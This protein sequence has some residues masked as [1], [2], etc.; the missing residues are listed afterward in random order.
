MGKTLKEALLK[1]PTGQDPDV[2][3]PLVVTSDSTFLNPA[4]K[5]KTE[6][7]DWAYA[8]LGYPLVN[9]ELTDAQFDVC[10]QNA[11]QLYTK[12]AYFDEKFLTVD[13][14][15]Y[16]PNKGLDLSQWNVV[17][18]KK[19]STTRDAMG[20]MGSSDFFFGW[21]ALLNGQYGG[22]P[23]FGSSHG[24]DLNWS[25]GFVTYQNFVEFTSL[26]RRMTGSNPD[27]RYDRSTKRL[28]LFPEPHKSH[29]NNPNWMLLT[30]ECE[31]PIEE[32]LGNEYVKRLVLANAKII[33]G[34]IRKKFS[35]VQLVGGGSIDTSIG[36][37]GREELDN[38]IENIRQD[39]ARGNFFYI[40]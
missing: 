2:K 7:K 10:I 40:G 16:E 13:L 15:F 33:L 22:G 5:S 25:G 30:V 34:T 18:V 37:E 35:S 6:L 28:L 31:P 1:T 8:M 39:E 38:L 9:V 29:T 36:D 20:G 24:N 14:N 27:F 11:I 23:F 19:I 21:P 32:L 12:Y 26:A 3:P 4:V 17:V